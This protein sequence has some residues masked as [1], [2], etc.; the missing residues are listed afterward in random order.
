M[1]NVFLCFY[2]DVEP[3]DEDEEQRK[4]KKKLRKGKERRKLKTTKFSEINNQI[5]S[6]LKFFPF[7]IN[8]PI[9]IPNF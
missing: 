4:K 6:V 1:Y 5:E 7:S 9:I 8:V 2:Q 3:G